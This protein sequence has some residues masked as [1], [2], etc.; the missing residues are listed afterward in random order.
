MR[1]SNLPAIAFLCVALLPVRCG[2]G[3]PE[4]PGAGGFPPMVVRVAPVQMQPVRVTSEYVAQ[5]KSRRSVDI[6]PQIEGHVA[7]IYVHAGQHVSASQ[8]LMQ[9]DPAR[10]Q[11]AVRGSQASR[12]AA[13]AA[14]KLARQQRTRIDGLY[15]SGVVSKQELDQADANLSSAQ[16]QVNSLDSEVSAQRVEL[17]YYNI[18]AP[19]AGIIGDIPAR[20]G[21][22]VTPST[23]LTT[24]DQNSALEAYISVPIEKAPL[25][26][27][28]VQVEILDDNEEVVATG[29]IN[30]ISPRVSDATQSILAKA[31]ITTGSEHLRPS[32]FSR[33]R[34]IWSVRQSP[35]VPTT[36]VTRLGGKP[37]VF[38]AADAGKGLI[39][40]Q[41]P[42][43]LGELSGDTYEITSGIKAGETVVVA[44]LQKLRDGAPV[45]P[46]ADKPAG[47]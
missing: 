3:G 24:L 44:G 16:A 34:V 47:S 46:E 12:S 21:D 37:F 14:L 20:E 26:H 9:I 2:K 29:A 10:Q 27:N 35:V 45:Q 17:R 23:V 38:V 28:G 19:S 39:V 41:T 8:Q 1:F 43:E 6:Q 33:A 40:H 32:Q 7:R 18:T 13:E 4:G 31:E 30:F 42:V 5:I 22:L 36:A 15:K 11:Q 25:L